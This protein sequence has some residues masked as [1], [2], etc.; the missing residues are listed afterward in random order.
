V[1]VHMGQ[2]D[3]D[4]LVVAA[5]SVETDT[6]AAAVAAFHQAAVAAFHQAA[7]AAVLQA[8]A[9]AFHQVGALGILVEQ[10]MDIGG[11]VELICLQLDM[12]GSLVV[13]VEALGR[14]MMDNQEA[15]NSMEVQLSVDTVAAEGSQAVVHMGKCLVDMSRLVAAEHH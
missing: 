4:T 14:G 13:P 9:A 6:S 12:L 15:V 8:A 11:W 5:H 3:M 10:R 1:A 7:A 2:R